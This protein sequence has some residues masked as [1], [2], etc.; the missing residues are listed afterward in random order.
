MGRHADDPDAA[1]PSAP[2]RPAN[3]SNA[4][5]VPGRPD[6]DSSDSDSDSG[7]VSGHGVPWLAGRPRRQAAQTCVQRRLPGGRH[8][9][10]QRRGGDRRAARRAPAGGGRA[11][12]DPGSRDSGSRCSRDP[13]HPLHGAPSPPTPPPPPPPP[14]P[15]PSPAVR[16]SDG[17]WDRRVAFKHQGLKLPRP[18]RRLVRRLG[19]C[20]DSNDHGR[21]DRRVRP[22]P[23]PNKPPPQPWP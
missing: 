6:S 11:R 23:G 2:P 21:E 18:L 3:S 20:L 17:G 4:V 9:P 8:D 10:A 7:W 1:A 22:P 16:E 13:S 14:L 5:R 19:S 15:P 12:H